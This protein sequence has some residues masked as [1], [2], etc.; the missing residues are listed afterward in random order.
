M[1][2]KRPAPPPINATET[3]LLDALDRIKHDRPTDPELVKLSKLKRLRVTVTNVA[4][5]AG[6]SRTLIGHKGCR[7][8]RVRANILA[9]M[10]AVAQPRTAADVI[11]RKRDEV[12]ALTEAVR[13]RDSVNAAL[14]LRLD[15]LAKGAARA[16]R[17]TEREANHAS[18][19]PNHIAGSAFCIPS[20]QSPKVVPQRKPR[21]PDELD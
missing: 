16:A 6:Q 1:P 21:K 3:K 5:E 17:Q 13:L 20:E 2:R 19:N 11:N 4:L 18:A 8:P 10:K 15:S 12:A 7:Y 14:I 9:E